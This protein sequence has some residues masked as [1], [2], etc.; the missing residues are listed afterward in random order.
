MR[1]R[2]G[3]RVLALQGEYSWFGPSLDCISYLDPQD[4]KRIPF[5]LSHVEANARLAENLPNFQ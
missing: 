2:K 5:T 4:G 3:E 1:N